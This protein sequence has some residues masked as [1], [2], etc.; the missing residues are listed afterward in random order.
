MSFENFNTTLFLVGSDATLPIT[1]FINLRDGS[2]P[3][4][5]AVSLVLM[6]GSAA[7]GL[8]GILGGFEVKKP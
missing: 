6:V 8:I 2:T 7:L 5:N 1:M 3:V 4:I